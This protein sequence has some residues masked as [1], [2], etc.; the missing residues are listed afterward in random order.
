MSTQKR[1]LTITCTEGND[2]TKK[3][4]TCFVHNLIADVKKTRP[5]VV[6]KRDPKAKT[7]ENAYY[8]NGLAAGSYITLKE[9][10]DSQG[11]AMRTTT[12]N[13]QQKAQAAPTA[14]VFLH[15]VYKLSLAHLGH[16]AGHFEC[17]SFTIAASDCYLRLAGA[18][19]ADGDRE[20][21]CKGTLGI[22]PFNHFHLDG[23]ECKHFHGQQ[24]LV[25]AFDFLVIVCI[26]NVPTLKR[27]AGQQFHIEVQFIYAVCIAPA[28]F[29]IR[30]HL[31][32]R[33]GTSSQQYYQNNACAQNSLHSFFLLRGFPSMAT[34][35]RLITCNPRFFAMRANLYAPPQV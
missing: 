10:G 16:I 20:S 26:D 9:L 27:P 19:I 17:C 11:K 15:L 4:L 14:W 12:K 35:P 7:G 22:I 25:S 6:W 34:L 5:L 32:R 2:V 24:H 28:W 23:I 1:S 33:C 29:C 8:T 30:R 18:A 21:R 31:L 3:Q 13:S